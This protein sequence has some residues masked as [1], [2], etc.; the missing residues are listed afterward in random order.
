MQ[1]TLSQ[2]HLAFFILGPL[3]SLQGVRNSLK[4]P[5]RVKIKSKDMSPWVWAIPLWWDI[6]CL[7]CQKHPGIICE[8]E[9]VI[10]PLNSASLDYRFTAEHVTLFWWQFIDSPGVHLPEAILVLFVVCLLGWT[11]DVFVDTKLDL[12]T[13]AW[14]RSWMKPNPSWPRGPWTMKTRRFCIECKVDGLSYSLRCLEVLWAFAMPLERQPLPSGVSG[15]LR[16]QPPAGI[17]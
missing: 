3:G 15:F 10:A 16:Y 6:F 14:P 2:S 4:G 17:F 12:L 8:R 5:L 7:V 13:E 11:R 9:G 1:C